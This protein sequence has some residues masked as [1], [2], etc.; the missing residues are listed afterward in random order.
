MIKVYGLKWVPPM[1]QGLVRDLR[2][3]W[4]LEEAGLPYEEELVGMEELASNHYRAL[5]PFGQIPVYQED[6]LTL[7]ESGAIVLH[8]AEKS[9]KLMPRDAVARPQVISWMF[10][11]LNSIEPMVQHLGIMDAF[12]N[13]EEWQ[14][15][16]PR[17]VQQIE[18][19][20]NALA[21]RLD[22]QDYLMGRFTAADILMAT[23]LRILRETDLVERRYALNR[24]K[25]RC[26]ARPAFQRALE[27]QLAAYDLHE[28]VKA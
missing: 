13:S 23:V 20:L 8:I 10:A 3:R 27:A 28:P 25:Q 15:L 4:A 6:D 9:E 22:G 16:R 17:A 12:S 26:E 19:R 24:Y 21:Q 7:F 5:Q 11:A 1:V 18:R 14:K 2:L